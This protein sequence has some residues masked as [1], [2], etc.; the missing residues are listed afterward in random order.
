MNKD[1]DFNKIRHYFLFAAIM[2][3]LP[4]ILSLYTGKT[5]H[6]L[7]ATEK[8][9]DPNFSKTVLYISHNSLVGAHGIVINKKL[10]N[11]TDYYAHKGVDTYDGGPL[12]ADHAKYIIVN[13]PK[14]SSQWQNQPITVKEI[15]PWKNKSNVSA[16]YLGYAGW[17]P[18]QLEQEIKNGFWRV[19]PYSEDII[20][21]PLS[22]EALWQSLIEK[23]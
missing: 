21:S 3:A 9:T 19:I 14:S 22:S 23:K 8:L 11:N 6:I 2:I 7:V 12:N 10:K 18:F 13:R 17:K 1:I 16:I 20:E 5:G 15:N 4:P